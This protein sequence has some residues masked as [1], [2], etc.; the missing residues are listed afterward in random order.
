MKKYLLKNYAVWRSSIRWYWINCIISHFPSR[1]VRNFLLNVAGA[2]LGKISMFAGFEIRNPKGLTI[3]NGSSIGPRVTLDARRNLTIGENVTIASEV[4]IW[5]L[6]HDYNDEFF[7]TVGKEV[8]IE[9][10]VWVCSRSIILPGVKIGKGAV[11][12]SGSVVTKDVEPYA[13][14]GG[15]PAKKIGERDKKEFKYSPYY[16]MHLV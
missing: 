15:I 4:M 2:N 7:K 16:K 9:E 13:I 8:I 14:M 5:T 10:Y 1:S 11:V 6:H 3:G 12:A